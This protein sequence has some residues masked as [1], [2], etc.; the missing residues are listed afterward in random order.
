MEEGGGQASALPLSNAKT[1]TRDLST[2]ANSLLAAGGP[3]L[4]ATTCTVLSSPAQLGTA[5]PALTHPVVMVT[6][7]VQCWAR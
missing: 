5:G 4:H 2:A 7:A 1:G 3:M 6:T